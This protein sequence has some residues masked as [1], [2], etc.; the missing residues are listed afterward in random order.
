M[1]ELDL[2]PWSVSPFGLLN[3]HK[4]VV[5][6][7]MDREIYEADSV[8]FHPNRNTASVVLTRAMFHRFLSTLEH[9]INIL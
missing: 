9:K 6:V 5:E 7:Y 8:N 4:K 3:D 1:E 2:E